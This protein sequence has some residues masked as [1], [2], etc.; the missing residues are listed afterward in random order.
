[1]ATK[2]D[3]ALTEMRRR[4]RLASDH[5]RTDYD[6]SR[7]DVKFVDVP[8][9]QWDSKLKARR[10][11]RP[12]YE[13]PKLSGHCRNVVNEMR[14]SRPQGKV[15]GAEESDRAL[16]EIMNGIYRNIES[17]SNAEQAYDVAYDFAVKGGIGYWR[18]CT[19]YAHDDDFEQDIFIE[20]IRNPFAV[21]PDPAAIKLDKRDAGYYFVEELIS[22]TEHERRFPDADLKDFD[23]D[24]GCADW[25][26]SDQVRIAEYWEKVPQKRK[27]WALS[28]G[29][30]VFADD[31]AKQAGMDENEA[32]DFLAATGIQIAKE[33]EVDSHKVVMRLTNGHE[34]LGEAHEFPSKYIPIVP[35]WGNIQNIDGKDVFYGMVRPNKDQQRLHNVH[36]TA[37]IE[38]VAKSPKAPYIVKLGW[39]KGLERFWKNANAEDYPYLPVNDSAEGIPQRAGQAEIPAALLQL[40]ALDNEDIKAG[41]GQYDASLGARSNETSGRAIAQR[42]QQGANATFNYVDN[43][44]YAIRYSTEIL[45]DMIPRVYDTQRVV[46]VLGPDGAEEWKTLYQEV[47]SPQTGMPVVLNDIRKGKYDVTVTVGPAYA[48]QRMEMAE[49]MTQLLGQIGPAFPPLAPIMAHYVI[50]SLDGPGAEEF[51]DVVRQMLVK[52]GLL[53]PEDG[54]EPPAP[55]QPNPKDM[56]DAEKAANQAK[57]YGAQAEHQQIE[58]MATVRALTA[59][60][61][62]PMMPMMQPPQGGF[63]SP[64][65][66]YPTG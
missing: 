8:G 65:Q 26:D 50:K 10:G 27:L 34:W 38:A 31:L 60:A 53:P 20:P 9:N 64:E 36:R 39:I 25:R 28:D 18:I 54:D 56:A 23:D 62:M 5:Y 52:Q 46:R 61:P 58:N 15:R 66:G 4:Y 49:M 32:R 59:P 11:D 40:A 30:V 43:L 29:R 45:I 17:V 41:T 35:V 13:F 19:D 14:Q 48:T 24:S 21:K 1:M 42:K 3:K 2:D 63:F 37:A 44:A 6:Q 51:S 57:L 47:V 33:R 12:T 7:D 55:P 16:A 22:L